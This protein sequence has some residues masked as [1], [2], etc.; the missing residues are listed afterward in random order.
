MKKGKG[1]EKKQKKTDAFRHKH[2][3]EA[4]PQKGW[5][6]QHKNGYS[7]HN[8][9]VTAKQDLW[10]MTELLNLLKLNH[11]EDVSWRWT[12]FKTSDKNYLKW[13]AK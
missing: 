9:T 13:M 8:N 7:F 4:I 11:N 3:F 12:K 10:T 6:F 5:S 1:W 2:I